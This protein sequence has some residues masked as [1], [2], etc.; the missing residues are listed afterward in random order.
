MPVAFPAWADTHTFL[1]WYPGAEGTRE[2]ASPILENLTTYLAQH[3]LS[4][5]TL[6]PVYRNCPVSEGLNEIKKIKPAIGIVSPE[7]YLYLADKHSVTPLAQTRNQASGSDSIHYT[8]FQHRDASTPPTLFITEPLS[9]PFARNI[10][11]RNAPN[12][13]NIPL[14]YVGQVLFT[15]K[16]I[17]RAEVSAAILL[18]DYEEAVLAKMK[19]PW[20]DTLVRVVSSPK[21]PSSPLILFNEWKKKLPTETLTEILFKMA[22]DEEGSEI[23]KQLRLV[24]FTKPDEAGYQ[25][26]RTSLAAP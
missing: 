6:K 13:R 11:L 26:L 20:K 16:K 23:L 3:G 19:S 18:N 25:A 2:Q 15:L 4:E 7:A 21:L 12:Y 8:V 5:H 22:N 9:K 10:V 17:G 14:K 1:F 24:G